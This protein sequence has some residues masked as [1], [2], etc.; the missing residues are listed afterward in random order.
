MP[1]LDSLPDPD[2]IKRWEGQLD[3]YVWRGL[4]IVRKWPIMTV[5]TRSPAVQAQQAAYFQWLRDASQ[6][7]APLRLTALA[8]TKGSHW[9]WRDILCFA[10]R[11]NL[12][13]PP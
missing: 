8:Q 12:Y 2:T 5:K 10:V 13:S 6:T 11:G 4:P 3:Y 9:T 7:A 1:L